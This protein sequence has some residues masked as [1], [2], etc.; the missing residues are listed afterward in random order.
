M[1][2][3]QQISRYDADWVSEILN[4]VRNSSRGGHMHTA[5]GLTVKVF[6][7]S[8]ARLFATTERAKY[9]HFDNVH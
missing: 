4:D 5:N 1:V 6:N 2:V 9:D 7:S 8:W 3:R